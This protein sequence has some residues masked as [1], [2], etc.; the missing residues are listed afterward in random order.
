MLHVA[1]Q[2]GNLAA[3][4]RLL[5]N[6]E[7]AFVKR[8]GYRELRQNPNVNAQDNMGYTPLH[9]A[10]MNGDAHI[11]TGTAF[12]S[13]DDGLCRLMRF[14]VRCAAALC[15]AGADANIAAHDGT[16]PANVSATQPVFQ[17]IR[18]R[19][20]QQ[21]LQTR[22][23]ELASRKQQLQI[24]AIRAKRT[25]ATATATATTTDTSTVGT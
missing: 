10:A 12:P 1:V 2:S 17:V 14:L 11:A 4:Q 5:E 13:C 3:V 19:V 21:A 18:A 6:S 24:A 22:L 9:L 20:E 7:H 23:Q 8:N 25:T 15:D 16:T